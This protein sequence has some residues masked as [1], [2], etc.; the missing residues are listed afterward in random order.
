LPFEIASAALYDSLL[1][2]A[3]LVPL[4]ASAGSAGDSLKSMADSM[5]WSDC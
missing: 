5:T 3:A 4:L 2:G 1:E